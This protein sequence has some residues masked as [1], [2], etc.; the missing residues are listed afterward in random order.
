MP[1]TACPPGPWS[2]GRVAS[3]PARARPRVCGRFRWASAAGRWP[4]IS[5]RLR[6]P[7]PPPPT[8][9]RG[10]AASARAGPGCPGHGPSQGASL[11]DA[12]HPPASSGSHDDRGADHRR[13]AVL[14]DVQPEQLRVLKN[15]Q[16]HPGQP[17]GVGGQARARS[18]TGNALDKT[19][20]GWSG[21][22]CNKTAHARAVS[23]AAT[24]G[25]GSAEFRGFRS[26]A[27]RR[28][29]RHRS[30]PRN[31]AESHGDVVSRHGSRTPFGK[32]GQPV[33]AMASMLDQAGLL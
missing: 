7:P 29:C 25:G 14:V 9:G 31:S 26:Y 5:A 10:R 32:L 19:G 8:G 4:P 20:P 11:A 21:R 6:P 18:F 16:R 1:P 27:R 12:A 28:A 23:E 2:A 22:C 3:S 17:E 24:P 13:A 30:A 33:A 15:D